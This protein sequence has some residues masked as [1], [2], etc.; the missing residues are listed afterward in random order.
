MRRKVV[1]VLVLGMALEVSGLMGTMEL[2]REKTRSG[3]IGRVLKEV[4]QA[5]SLIGKA[6]DGLNA[7]KLTA[8]ALS[9]AVAALGRGD[10]ARN[11]FELPAEVRSMNQPAGAAAGLSPSDEAGAP[12]GSVP[13]PPPRELNGILVGPRDRVAIIDGTLLRMGD[14][15][16]GEHVVDIGRD[17]VVL[18]RDGQHRTLRLPPP[19]P[20]S[21]QPETRSSADGAQPKRS[22]GAAKP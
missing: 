6:Q 14:T 19:F 16:E 1:V 13:A 2:L 10:P 11:P 9:K 22:N 21:G 17:H 5:R 7:D 12:Q 8:E 4:D 3:P 15:L 18:A 20:E